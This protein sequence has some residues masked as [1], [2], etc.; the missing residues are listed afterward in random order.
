MEMSYIW[1]TTNFQNWR[2]MK[3]SPK[4]NFEK[5]T[6]SK[7]SCATSMRYSQEFSF[8]L[9]IDWEWIEA[10]FW[11]NKFILTKNKVFI[12]RG[13]IKKICFSKLM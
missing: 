3:C 13:H 4:D 9:I 10:G 7:L 1:I 5:G 12:G 8:Q 6:R 2:H 11:I